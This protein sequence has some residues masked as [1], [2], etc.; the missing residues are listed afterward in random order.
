MDL[1]VFVGSGVRIDSVATYR[2]A[3][4][5]IVGTILKEDGRLDAPVDVERVRALAEAVASLRSAE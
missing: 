3:D 5:F 1:P 2:E 4:G